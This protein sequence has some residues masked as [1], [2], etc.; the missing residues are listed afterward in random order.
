MKKKIVNKLWNNGVILI[1]FACCFNSYVYAD[2]EMQNGLLSYPVRISFGRA[3]GTSVK[4]RY[5]APGEKQTYKHGYSLD[6]VSAEYSTDPN[7]FTQDAKGKKHFN[8]DVEWKLVATL[9]KGFPWW[10]A[11]QTISVFPVLN[12]ETGDVMPQLSVTG[13]T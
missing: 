4:P 5:L 7:A 8:K 10:T 11:K 3:G 6:R 12:T 1:L 13:G 9:K 2:T